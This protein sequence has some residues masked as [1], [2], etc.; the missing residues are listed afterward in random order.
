[1][2]LSDFILLTQEQKRFTVLNEGVLIAKRDILN[3]MVFLFQMKDYYVETFCSVEHKDIR[4]FRVLHN[5][6]NLN[7]YIESIPLDHLFK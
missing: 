6:K 7:P 3:Y 2:K 1:M 5:T 4:E